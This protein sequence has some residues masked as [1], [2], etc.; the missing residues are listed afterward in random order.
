M[1]SNV[2]E[3]CDPSVDGKLDFSLETSCIDD[4]QGEAEELA[5]EPAPVPLCPPRV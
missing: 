2:L 4:Q 5:E 3:E 1:Q